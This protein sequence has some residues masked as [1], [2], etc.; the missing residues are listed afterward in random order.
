MMSFPP[1]IPLRSSPSPYQSNIIFFLSLSP[2][3]QTRKQK[4][5]QKVHKKHKN[6]I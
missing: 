4:Q 5:I 6:K 1:Q 2:N 3:K